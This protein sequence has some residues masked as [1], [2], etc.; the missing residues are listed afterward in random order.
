MIDVSFS[1]PSLYRLLGVLYFFLRISTTLG[2]SVALQN[3]T[4]NDTDPRIYYSSGWSDAATASSRGLDFGKKGHWSNEEGASAEFTSRTGSAVYFVSPLWPYAVR[5][6]LSIDSG[7]PAVVDLQAVDREEGN[8]GLDWRT[9]RV[10]WGTGGLENGKHT[11]RIERASEAQ[12]VVLGELIYTTVVSRSK[13]DSISDLPRAF[14]SSVSDQ[15]SSSHHHT[16]AILHRFQRRDQQSGKPVIVGVVVGLVIALVG[17]GIGYL[18][19]RYRDILRAKYGHLV[20]IPTTAGN[21]ETLPTESLPNSPQATPKPPTFSTP[22]FSAHAQYAKG[23]NT[24]SPVSAPGSAT[25]DREKSLPPPPPQG[26]GTPTSPT[27]GIARAIA[28]LGSR[29]RPSLFVQVRNDDERLKKNTTTKSATS[30]FFSGPALD[31]PLNKTRTASVISQLDGGNEQPSHA[32]AKPLAPTDQTFPPSTS[33]IRGPDEKRGSNDDAKEG[34][35]SYYLYHRTNSTSSGTA[36]F[37]TASQGSPLSSS[38]EILGHHSYPP[39]SSMKSNVKVGIPLTSIAE[40][41]NHSMTSVL[42][43]P[44]SPRSTKS[45]VKRRSEARVRAEKER[46]RRRQHKII[47]SPNG[48][49]DR[50]SGISRS[51][52]RAYSYISPVPKSP[53]QDARPTARRLPRP[54]PPHPVSRTIE[55]LPGSRPETPLPPYPMG[56]EILPLYYEK[57]KRS[58][59]KSLRAELLSPPT[60][61]Q[62]FLPSPPPS[63]SGSSTGHESPLPPQTPSPRPLPS[64]S[65]PAFPTSPRKLPVPNRPRAFTD[66]TAS[67]PPLFSAAAHT[68]NR[69]VDLPPI[70]HLHLP[71][72]Y[73]L[74]P[75]TQIASDPK[76]SHIKQ[77][78]STDSS[79]SATSTSASLHKQRPS[80][81]NHSRSG[82]AATMQFKHILQEDG[83]KRPPTSVPVTPNMNSWSDAGTYRYTIQEEGKES[84]A[85]GI[86]PSQTTPRTLRKSQLGQPPLGPLPSL[87]S[88]PSLPSSSD[89]KRVMRKPPPLTEMTMTPSFSA[90]VVDVDEPHSAPSLLASQSP[91]TPINKA[92]QIPPA[93]VS[94]PPPTPPTP[95]RRA[96]V[97]DGNGRKRGATTISAIR[98]VNSPLAKASTKASGSGGLGGPI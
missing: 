32:R 11:V 20:G 19:V 26:Q 79:T 51:S 89:K 54:L 33:S 70:S 39:R 27:K 10:L 69:S 61:S 6:Q 13:V 23:R 7:P 58:G 65:K 63:A 47:P 85:D 44:S 25:R 82:P 95:R 8:A 14:K 62:H 77:K 3:V 64:I 34:G 28:A 83:E 55:S 12:Y 66:T 80:P 92:V 84:D 31:A 49:R 78:S 36:S 81:P 17:V 35:P 94:P 72:K 1:S 24:P 59:R 15:P 2:G 56:S 98:D 75:T 22:V 45:S 52:S 46:Q 87:P 90:T 93:P 57:V 40:A 88:V 60:P 18:M 4:I 74:I 43:S 96:K 76:S 53:A 67:A 9:P 38:P 30:S 37:N 97:W 29:R 48:P 42:D 71:Q 5:V 50:Y 86:M 73:R 16:P 21:D 41:P 68:R 91:R